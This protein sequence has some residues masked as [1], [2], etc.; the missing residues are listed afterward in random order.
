MKCV[1]LI[2]IA[3]FVLQNGG[4]D[5]QRK[6]KYCDIGYASDLNT[7]RSVESSGV[8]KP[9]TLELWQALLL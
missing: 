9:R 4:S 3:E 7:P 2:A 6:N 1:D 8:S 5:G